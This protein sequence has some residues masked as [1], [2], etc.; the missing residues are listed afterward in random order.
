M[1]GRIKYMLRTNDFYIRHFQ[2]RVNNFRFSIKILSYYFHY[3]K[4]KKDK[5]VTGNTIYFIIEQKRQHPGLVDRLKVAVCIYY[6]A[7]INGFNFKFIIETPHNLSNYL[8]IN[9]I[10]WLAYKNDLSYSLHNSRLLAYNGADKFPHLNK[11][12]KQYH[13]YFYNGFDILESNNIANFRSIW[14]ECFNE[15]FAPTPLLLNFIKEQKYSLNSYIAVHLRFVN[16]LENFEQGYYNSLNDV[17]KSNLI[18]RCLNA[19]HELEKKNQSY[20]LVVFS[21]SMK[22]LE[23]AKINKFNIID[24]MVGHISFCGMDEAVVLKTILDFY[25]ISRAKKVNMIIA[26]EMYNSAFSFYAALSGGKEI[27]FVKV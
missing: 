6:I 15:L 25:L 5:S 10:N 23:Q 22:F 18:N 20:P 24:G 26:P 2:T 21:D 19:L 16:A 1:I 17:Q 7:K 9:Q 14:Q 13:I 8:G 27:E 12:I 11:K 4:F 3:Y